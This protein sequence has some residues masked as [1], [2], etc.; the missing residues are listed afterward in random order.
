MACELR[1]FKAV[2]VQIRTY[3]TYVLGGTYAV[4]SRMLVRIVCPFLDYMYG[5]NQNKVPVFRIIHKTLVVV[6]SVA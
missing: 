1:D 3:R 2:R 6:L 4:I 5:T